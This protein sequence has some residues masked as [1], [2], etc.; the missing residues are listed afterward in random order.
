MSASRAS[1]GPLGDHLQIGRGRSIRLPAPLLPILDSRERDPV[2]P[3]KFHLRH[4]QPSTD[5]PHV[6]HVDDMDA[7]PAAL[8]FGVLARLGHALDQLLAEGRVRC[9]A[10]LHQFS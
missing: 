5:R 2:C 6:G 7:H 3:R 8:A 9:H 1:R 4:P 10:A